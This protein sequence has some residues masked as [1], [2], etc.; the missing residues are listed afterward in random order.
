MLRPVNPDNPLLP[1]ADF[2]REIPKSLSHKS[3]EPSRSSVAVVYPGMA[4][5]GVSSSFCGKALWRF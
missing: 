3:Q 5:F 2:P 1:K 4:Q